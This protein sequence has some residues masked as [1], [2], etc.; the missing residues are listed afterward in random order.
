MAGKAF[1]GFGRVFEL[2]A[3]FH[4]VACGHGDGLDRIADLG[5]DLRRRHVGR[6]IGPRGD[7]LNPVSPVDDRVLHLVTHAIDDLFDRDHG[8]RGRHH[9]LI[10]QAQ[11]RVGRGAHDDRQLA[12]AL[13]IDAGRQ[14]VG[15]KGEDAGDVIAGDARG[16][17]ALGDVIGPQHK[18]LFAPVRARNQNVRRGVLHDGNRL[19]GKVAQNLG[20]AARKPDLDRCAAAGPEDQPRGAKLALGQLLGRKGLERGLQRGNGLQCFGADDHVPIGRIRAFARIGQQEPRG[21][22][23]HEGGKGRDI[24]ALGQPILEPG[25]LCRGFGDGR[26]LRQRVIHEEDRRIGVGKELLTHLA[27]A[28]IAGHR[29]RQKPRNHQPAQPE[30]QAQRACEDPE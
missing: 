1:I 12:L 21:S 29:D 22:L 11:I 23:A 30:R 19:I 25:H 2:A 28:P 13:A 20:V 14:S 16:L 5:M 3:P 9:H 17:G 15:G 24:L 8:P 7:R 10:H 6:N 26:A 27:K 4:P 18:F